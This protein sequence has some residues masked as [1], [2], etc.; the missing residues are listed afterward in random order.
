MREKHEMP[1][2]KVSDIAYGWLRAP[3]LDRMEAFLLDF[4][5]V[6][7]ERIRGA[8]STSTGRTATASTR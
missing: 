6:R 5:M 3:D 4:G 8:A 1:V 7:A 2:V